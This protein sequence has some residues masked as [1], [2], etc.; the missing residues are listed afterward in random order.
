[1]TTT[2][3]LARAHAALRNIPELE[4][5]RVTGI[6]ALRGGNHSSFL[7]E[8]NR[9][10]YVLRLRGP[11]K[12]FAPAQDLE[13]EFAVLSL[14]SAED[15]AP[16]PVHADPANGVMLVRFLE[17][18]TLSCEDLQRPRWLEQVAAVLARVH[19][20]RWDARIVEPAA[21]VRGYLAVLENSMTKHQ[22]VMPIRR[23]LAGLSGAF[24]QGSPPV[25][26]HN[27]LLSGNIHAGAKLRLL[28][29]EYAG[30]G[31]PWYDIATLICYHDLDPGARTALVA[32]YARYSGRQIEPARLA[33][34]C[35]IVDCQTL[36]W[37][38]TRIESGVQLD[39]DAGLARSAAVRLDLE[40]RLSG[41][42]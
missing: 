25:L 3:R 24:E 1:M 16:Q 7:V 12:V 32:A 28:D 41:I 21:A 37:A 17:G 42:F 36:A 20:H 33:G 38:L 15:L 13:H 29:W 39:R 35:G 6:V 2:D 9:G 5:A 14:M 40:Q 30:G 34:L 27:D 26:C 8:S 18:R 22:A 11:A 19:R 10:D 23:I 31:D 4:G